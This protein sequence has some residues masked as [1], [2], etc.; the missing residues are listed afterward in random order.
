[1]VNFETLIGSLFYRIG[2]F[3]NLI[4][5]LRILSEIVDK[6]IDN[7]EIFIGNLSYLIGIYL[8]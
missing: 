8:E 6:L 3:E 2:N 5:K 1:M 4:G 7:F